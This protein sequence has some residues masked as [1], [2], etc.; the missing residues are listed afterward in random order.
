MADKKITELDLVETIEDDASFIIT[1]PDGEQAE[2]KRSLLSTLIAKLQFY[3]KPAG[4][5]PAS[6]IASGVIPTVP[7][8]VSELTNDSEYLTVDTLP[9]YD[10]S[11]T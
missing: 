5:I 4:G 1:Q 11:V 10:G 6:D 3:K 9:I 2:A 8:K 7:T